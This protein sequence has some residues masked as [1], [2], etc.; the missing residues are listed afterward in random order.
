MNNKIKALLN[1]NDPRMNSSRL[2][3][4]YH[5]VTQVLEYDVKGDVVELG[6]CDGFS[7]RVIAAIMEWQKSNK[8]LYLFD[9]FQGLPEFSEK[10]KPNRKANDGRTWKHENHPWAKPGMFAASPDA[11][12]KNLSVFDLLGCKKVIPGWF[13]DTVPKHLPDQICFAHLDGDLYESVKVS[14]EGVYPRLAKGAIC[15]I[16]DYDYDDFPG[17]TTAVNEFL[18]NKPEI[19]NNLYVKTLQG[20]VHAYFRKK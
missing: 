15:V 1:I 13:E 2:M 17:A 11:L 20:S 10:D 4:H 14:I 16:D 5:L 8:D 12:L 19:I 7:T 9:S 18:K 3:N 6:T